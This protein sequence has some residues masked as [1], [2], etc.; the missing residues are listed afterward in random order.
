MQDYPGPYSLYIDKEDGLFIA[1]GSSGF[2]G[3]NGPSISSNGNPSSGI[4]NSF[5]TKHLHTVV[6]YLVFSS[7]KYRKS[8]R[9]KPEQASMHLTLPILLYALANPIPIGIKMRR[10]MISFLLLIPCMGFCFD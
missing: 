1:G 3:L 4:K 10:Y 2:D 6:L 9:S 8:Y 5:L 7:C